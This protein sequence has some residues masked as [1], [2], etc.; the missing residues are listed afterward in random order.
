MNDQIQPNLSSDVQINP[1]SKPSVVII[2]DPSS[3]KSIGNAPP[4]TAAG[5]IVEKQCLN[6]KTLGIGMNRKQR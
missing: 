3:T 1:S 2:F 4:F 6:N 5:E